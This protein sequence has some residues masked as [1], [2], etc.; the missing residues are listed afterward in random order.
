[1]LILYLWLLA[2]AA[3]IA[4][5]CSITYPALIVMGMAVMIAFQAL[6]HMGIVTRGFP[7]VGAASASDIQ[8]WHIHNSDVY[9][10]R[11]NALGEPHGIA[12]R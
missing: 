5:R 4:S 3:G 1:M 6:F 10:I 7:C 8:G 9:S 12:P 11:H 2:R